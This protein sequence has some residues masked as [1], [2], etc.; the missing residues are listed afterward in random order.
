MP[1]VL[2]VGPYRFFFY[3]GDYDE[4][5]H[6]HVE[7]ESR[8]A[9]LWHDPVRLERSGGFSRAETQKIGRLVEQHKASL[10]RSWDEF[11]ND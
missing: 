10:L 2:R 9:K 7:R 6:I 3:A 11:F 4:P 1:T 5:P 8:T